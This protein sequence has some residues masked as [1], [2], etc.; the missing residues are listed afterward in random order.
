MMKHFFCLNFQ[1]DLL[2]S[3]AYGNPK[4]LDLL[5]NHLEQGFAVEF[6]SVSMDNVADFVQGLKSWDLIVRFARAHNTSLPASL[7]KC[8]AQEN[9]W[10]EFALVG[11]IFRY[12][13]EQVTLFSII[14]RY[15]PRKMMIYI[16]IQCQNTLFVGNLRW[17]NHLGKSKIFKTRKDFPGNSI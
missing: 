16:K 7:L 5:L 6:P 4:D 3:V 1:D 9:H 13:L 2:E 17:L 8:F 10:F 14:S 12:S 15:Y 11:N